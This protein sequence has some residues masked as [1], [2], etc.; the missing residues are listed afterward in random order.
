MESAGH[1]PDAGWIK[2]DL[3]ARGISVDQSVGDLIK[4]AAP[5]ALR[6]NFYNTPVWL[7][8]HY[9]LPQELRVLGLVVGLNAYGPSPWCLTWSREDVSLSLV[10]QTAGVKYG[11]DVVQDLNLFSLD[12]DAARVANLYGGAA[13]AFFSPRNCYFFSDSLQCGFCSLEGTAEET[14]G[15]KNV[16]SNEDIQNTVRSALRT[17]PGRIEQVMV[18][19]GNMRDLN[20]GF[21]HHVSLAR[22]AATEIAAA[23]FSETISVHIATMPPRDLSL[24]ELLAEIDNVHVMFNLEVWDAAVFAEMCPG[25]DREYGRSAMLRALE[26]LRD[27]IGAYR[28]HSLLVAGLESP[29]ST[30]A[31][32]AALAD[33]GISPIINVYH[34]DRH[35]RVGL[36][37][38]PQFAQLA[39]VALSLQEL[40]RKLPLRPYWRSCG[41]NAIDAEADG[42]LFRGPIPRFLMDCSPGMREN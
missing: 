37:V 40:Y 31:G 32:A 33:L 14:K 34:S 12:G 5:I 10:N 36:S 17:D 35:S 18:V 7:E 20:R 22:T 15:F 9:P 30:S 21:M 23:G 16:L 4:S 39:E 24:I 8:S 6:K 2:L 42:G 13:L 25:K 28:A 29:E 11:S 41:R 26:R 1:Y 19:G 27:T 3:L 38:R